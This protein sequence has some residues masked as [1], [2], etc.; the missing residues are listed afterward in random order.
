MLG[1][2]FSGFFGSDSSTNQN[3]GIAPQNHENPNLNNNY[4]YYPQVQ[5]TIP[6]NNFNNYGNAEYYSPNPNQGII[7]D[8][9]NY[10]NNYTKD[11]REQERQKR[12][13][14]KQKRELEKQ[15]REMER[16]QRELEKRLREGNDNQ[17]K[18]FEDE[19]NERRKR[20]EEE[21]NKILLKYNED[22]N[23][24]LVNIKQNTMGPSECDEIINKIKYN[25]LK[26]QEEINKI[27]EEY[28][29]KIE[30]LKKEQ[31]DDKIKQEEELTILK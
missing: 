29:Q 28:Q 27:N 8:Q 4:I 2:F 16:Q 23:K 21:W 30:K 24:N 19:E 10:D 17:I 7:N 31:M 6:K 18:Q 26:N 5:P 25:T 22:F 15:K 20:E 12:E 1:N 11:Q 3:N 14:E 9:N 13:I